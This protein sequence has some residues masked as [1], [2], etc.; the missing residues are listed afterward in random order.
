M[1][2]TRIF[3]VALLLGFVLAAGATHA[4]TLFTPPLVP[5]GENQLDCYLIN[6][7]DELRKATIEVLNRNGEVLK[8]V[9]VAL[10]PGTEEVATVEADELPRY[11]KFVVDGEFRDAVQLA[12]PS[13]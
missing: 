8:S 3:A 12:L 11:C 13:R 7:S 4:V 2:K 6:V 5:E 9:D 10:Y 1:S